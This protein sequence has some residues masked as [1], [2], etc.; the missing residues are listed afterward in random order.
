MLNSLILGHMVAHVLL[1]NKKT[2]I[3]VFWTQEQTTKAILEDRHLKNLLLV[4]LRDALIP[5][6]REGVTSDS[7]ERIEKYNYVDD[8]G[9]GKDEE[10]KVIVIGKEDSIEFTERRCV[11]H[12]HSTDVLFEIFVVP[13]VIIRMVEMILH[14]PCFN[15]NEFF[16]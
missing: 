10:L 1:R 7:N 12:A 16:D 9:H 3:W 11:G 8:R 2:F 5:N 15:L 6:V 14:N 4:A 13:G